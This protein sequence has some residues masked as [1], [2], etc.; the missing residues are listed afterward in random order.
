MDTKQIFVINRV[1]LGLLL[2]IPGLLKLFV[3][4]PGA[5]TEMLGANVLFS[6]APALWAWIL[7]FGEILFGVGIL[8]KFKM[9]Y[10][11]YGGAIILFIATLT[12]HINWGDLGA[13]AWPNVLV[14]LAAVTNFLMLACRPLRKK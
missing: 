1:V 6:W 3:M 4:G 11:A 7:I 2:L 12:V 13:T 9:D 5:V 8:A 10:A 14:H